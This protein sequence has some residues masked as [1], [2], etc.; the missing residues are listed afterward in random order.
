[1]SRPL[2]QKLIGIIEPVL[3]ADG[4]ELV[5]LRFLLEQ[6]GWV[7]RVCVDLP[8]DPS[9]PPSEVPQDRVDL[10]DCENI[11]RELSAV[12]DVD[13]PIP[14]AYSLEISSPGVDRPLRTPEHFIYFTGSDAKITLAAPM[15]DNGN[16]RRNFRGHLA[17]VSE[18]RTHALIDVDGRR[19][20]LPIADI[21]HAKLVPDWDAVMAGKSGAGAPQPK[22]VKPGH[23]PSTKKQKN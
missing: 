23:R 8:L 18:D 16:E 22:P 21:D 14:Q 20:S 3:Q 2:Q 15:I 1:M 6:N 9:V 7:L 12:L 11:S 10:A 4:F 17:G 13:D 19:F 5:D